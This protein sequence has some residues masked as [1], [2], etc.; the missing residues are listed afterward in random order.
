MWCRV[1]TP[2]CLFAGS[3]AVLLS[4][5][6]PAPA[7]PAAK[8]EFNRDIRPLLSDRC[9]ACH[10]PDKNKRKAD[11]RLD[12]KE[13]ALEVRKGRAAIVPSH[14]EKSELLRRIASADPEDRMPPP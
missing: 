5:A 11:L 10:G 2:I 9:Y 3:A 6:A 14:P 1:K 13:S 4:F 12:R 8:I 7:A